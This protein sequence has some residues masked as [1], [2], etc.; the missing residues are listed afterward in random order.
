M[1]L[2]GNLAYCEYCAHRFEAVRTFAD[3]TPVRLVDG[4]DLI[5]LGFK[6]GP[7]FSEILRVVEDLTLERKLATKEQALEYVVAKFVK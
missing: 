4:K 2:D 5:Q 3:R 6:P 1:S 7:E